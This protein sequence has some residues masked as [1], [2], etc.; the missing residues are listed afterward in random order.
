MLLN[1]L[2]I[3]IIIVQIVL[4]SIFLNKYPSEGF[5]QGWGASFGEFVSP[6]PPCRDENDC[7]RGHPA[8][9]TYY[10]NMCEPINFNSELR[11]LEP[12]RGLLKTKRD[13]R[14]SCVR[15]L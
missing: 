8:R 14:N 6:V 2:L 11:F 15:K 9:W 5:A 12:G 13:L 10:E 7:S 1:I 4:L 3:F